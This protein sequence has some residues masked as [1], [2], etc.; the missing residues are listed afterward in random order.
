[1][2]TKESGHRS[3]LVSSNRRLTRRFR[4]P[5]FQRKSNCHPLSCEVSNVVPPPSYRACVC[6]RVNRTPSET[7]VCPQNTLGSQNHFHNQHRVAFHLP[8]SLLNRC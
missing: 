2:W 4:P 3:V 6:T 5:P 8:V 1:M 7:F